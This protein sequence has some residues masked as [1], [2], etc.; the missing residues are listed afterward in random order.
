MH[1]SEAYHSGH[2]GNSGMYDYGGRDIQHSR[3]RYGLPDTHGCI[4][5]A[6]EAAHSNSPTRE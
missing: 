4:S 3:I 1:S 5:I 2:A 6:L